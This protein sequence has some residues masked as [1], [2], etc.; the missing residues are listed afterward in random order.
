MAG[1]PPTHLPH[2]PL[3][4]HLPAGLVRDQTIGAAGTTPI[5]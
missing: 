5:V 3:A 4:D 1:S 2:K